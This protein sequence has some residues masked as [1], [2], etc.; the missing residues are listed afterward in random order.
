MNDQK[1]KYMTQRQK[2]RIIEVSESSSVQNQQIFYDFSLIKLEEL[3]APPAS[4][5]RPND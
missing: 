4:P 2:E 3:N 5:S 1:Y